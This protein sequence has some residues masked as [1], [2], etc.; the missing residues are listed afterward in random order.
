M[1]NVHDYCDMA[2][3]LSELGSH[4]HAELLERLKLSDQPN[5]LRF[6][7]RVVVPFSG[8]VGEEVGRRILQTVAAYYSLLS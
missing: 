1:H 5:K 4:S 2:K 7:T 8:G 6:R 3:P